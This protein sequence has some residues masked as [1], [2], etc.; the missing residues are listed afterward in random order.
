[1]ESLTQ[2]I[3]IKMLFIIKLK[4][5]TLCTGTVIHPYIMLTAAHCL[6]DSEIKEIYIGHKTFEQ[7][8]SD[9][10]VL[11]KFIP[12]DFKMKN[13]GVYPR[14]DIALVVFKSKLPFSDSEIIKILDKKRYDELDINVGEKLIL[15]GFGKTKYGRS[16]IRRTREVEILSRNIFC[17]DRS[18]KN[19]WN[20]ELGAAHGDSGGPAFYKK[21]G[22]LYQVGV[23]SAG[24][25][26][27]DRFCRKSYYTNIIPHLSWIKDKTGY[28]PTI[29]LTSLSKVIEE[30]FNL[31]TLLH[32]EGESQ[33]EINVPESFKLNFQNATVQIKDKKYI[34]KVMKTRII[35]DHCF[36]EQL[37]E[38]K[39][40]FWEL[41]FYNNIGK[42]IEV[43]L[44]DF[45]FPI[46]N[47]NNNDEFIRIRLQ[48]SKQLKTRL[49]GIERRNY[50]KLKIDEID[51]DLIETI[52][53]IKI[54]ANLAIN[55]SQDNIDNSLNL[56]KYAIGVGQDGVELKLNLNLE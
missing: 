41:N 55:F 8:I 30:K 1:M 52:S 3:N 26:Y 51:S 23:T 31:V 18:I 12:K 22:K 42:K 53:T 10:H 34:Q 38:T 15:A 19:V 33:N 25:L 28:D 17:G 43:S 24:A 56:N 13:G 14:Y 35:I 45:S 47:F 5:N 54:P 37:C 46:K 6:H 39:A 40:S 9:A 11:K 29:S 32:Q 50:N 4:K 16:S 2:Q 49:Q 21:D 7:K 27:N 48:V 44:N 36:N 20:L